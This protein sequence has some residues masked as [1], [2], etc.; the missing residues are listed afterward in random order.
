MG[1]WE[2]HKGAPMGL[3]PPYYTPWKA[4]GGPI[5]SMG[6][7]G[8][9]QLPYSRPTAGLPSQPPIAEDLGGDV[10]VGGQ[11]GAGK[12]TKR[13]YGAGPNTQCPIHRQGWPHN[14]YESLWSPTAIL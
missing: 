6:L 4:R 3:P 14:F 10:E 7:C 8:T 9:L 2:G 5:A 1:S 12:D 11:W 13:F